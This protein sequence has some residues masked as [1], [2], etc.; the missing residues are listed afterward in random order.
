MTTEAGLRGIRR[1]DTA[2][3][4]SVWS[5]LKSE[6]LVAATVVDF[7]RQ[8][9]HARQPQSLFLTQSRPNESLLYVGQGIVPLRIGDNDPGPLAAALLPFRYNRSSIHGYRRHVMSLWKVLAAQWHEPR[10]VRDDQLLLRCR[11]PE[12]AT[13]LA[14]AVPPGLEPVR[15]AGPAEF[16]QVLP[17][18]SAM[19]LEELGMDP[20]VEPYAHGFRRRVANYLAAGKTWVAYC[21][22]QLAFK[23]DVVTCEFG[24]AV[25]QGVWTAP[26]LRGRGVASYAMSQIMV[27]LL[28]RGYT[29]S[30]VVNSANHAARTVYR[31]CGME[32]VDHYAT[33]IF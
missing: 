17:A 23:A 15:P 18:A 2:S 5:V 25:I 33:V 30:L 1:L 11:N 31:R 7:V 8:D 26:Q 4:A 21:R 13:I 12:A 14:R 27:T 20:L 3:D 10:E 19:Y 32:F 9:L 16:Y 24:V 29:P 6:A 22:N 28:S